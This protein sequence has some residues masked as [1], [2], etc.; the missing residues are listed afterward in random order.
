[1]HGIFAYP[2]DLVRAPAQF[3]RFLNF[4]EAWEVE[5]ISCVH[6][7]FMSLVGGCHDRVEDQLVEAALSSPGVSLDEEASSSEGV[8]MVGFA[9]LESD[10]LRLF[11][12]YITSR[13]NSTVSHI[14]SMGSSFVYRLIHTDDEALK[15]MVRDFDSPIRDFLPEAI[16]RGPWI[17]DM[18][19]GTT[20]MQDAQQK[21]CPWCANQGFSLVEHRGGK[22]YLSIEHTH[23]YYAL[24]ERGWVFW[25]SGR[26]SQRQVVNSLDEAI[27]M[28]NEA[29]RQRYDR[30]TRK[31]VE[32]RLEGV[33]VPRIERDRLMDEFGHP[34]D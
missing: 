8:D 10:R 22:Y 18:P 5:E 28:N 2:D 32:E 4:L 12:K 33:R 27:S 15:D 25:N 14:A 11:G 1:M 34:D 31:S 29:A 7:Y 16:D 20:A 6:C 17:H 24:R 9:D 26:I 30:A 19:P 3:S 21:E 13:G 23:A